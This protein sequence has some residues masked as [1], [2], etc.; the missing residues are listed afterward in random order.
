MCQVAYATHKA[1]HLLLSWR[2]PSCCACKPLPLLPAQRL[3]LPD[4]AV[5][6]L[7]RPV[8]L[9]LSWGPA[10]LP[11]GSAAGTCLEGAAR[12]AVW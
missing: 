9:L 2:K 5:E 4:R 1:A 3:L 6:N 10:R 8:L 12:E 7:A 11:R